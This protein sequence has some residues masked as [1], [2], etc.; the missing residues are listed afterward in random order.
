MTYLGE[1]S[2]VIHVVFGTIGLVA[3][4]IPIFTKK[5]AVNHVR[6]GKVF[7]WS[8]Y[9]VLGAAGIALAARAIEMWQQ[10]RG[11]AEAPLL[12]AFMVFLGYL[13]FVTF[14]IVRHGMQVLRTKRQPASIKTPLNTVL[15]YASI[16]ASGG[17]ILFALLLNPANKILLFALSPIGVGTGYG[18]LKY[19]GGAQQSPRSWFYEHLGAMLGAGIAFHTAFAVFGIT[20]LFDIGLT[21]WVAVIPWIAPT[22]IGI[23][24]IS[25][26]TKHYQ[27]KF[28]ELA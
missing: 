2:R 14:V 3:F 11:Y 4:W 27:R 22:V 16:A 12:V 23:P 21:G 26:W 7:V 19:M 10:G 25:I 8:A 5:G 17:I 1:F 6:F 28:G 13:T 24:A 15:A 18:M 9:V 20:R